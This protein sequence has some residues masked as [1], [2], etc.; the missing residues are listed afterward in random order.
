MNN[1]KYI[2]FGLF[3][4]FMLVSCIVV[5]KDSDTSGYQTI[6]LS[7]K[8]EIAMSENTVRSYDGDMIAFLPKDWFFVDF[9]N[10]ASSEIFAVAVNP[11]YTLSLVFLSRKKSQQYS[12]IVESEGLFGLSRVA[13]DMHQK[14]AGGAVAS[15]GK[16]RKIEMGNMEFVEFEFASSAGGLST[17]AAVFISGIGNYYEIALTPMTFR[18]KPLPTNSE[19]EMIFRSVL[20]TVQF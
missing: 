20:A 8:P 6:S 2:V 5:K 15:I 11:D 10:H 7:P 17:K 9:E 1:M 19:M 3:A 13:L 12:D 16:P 18:G 14:K 4:M